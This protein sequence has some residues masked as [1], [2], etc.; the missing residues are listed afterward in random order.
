MEFP[1]SLVVGTVARLSRQKGIEYLLHAAKTVIKQFPDITFIIAGKGPLESQ[2]KGLSI[3]L[4]ISDKVKF[5]GFN[6]DIPKLLSVIDIFVLPSLWEGMPN[7]VL[8]A[9]AAGKPVI[10]TDTG[11]SKDI[12]DSGING[13]LVEP[14]NSE[15]LAE[16]I[17]ALL[18]DPAQRKRLGESARDKVKERFPIDK[19]VSKTEQ[20]YTKLLNQ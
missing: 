10:A 13:V 18:G 20:I 1:D 4:G 3:K 19:M 17:L 8:E 7:V 2:L 6:D 5:L 12:I 15:A 16:A 9:M 11:G 14:K